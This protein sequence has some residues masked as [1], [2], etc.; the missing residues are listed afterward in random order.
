[1]VSFATTDLYLQQITVRANEV[2]DVEVTFWKAFVPCSTAVGLYTLVLF[3]A[4]TDQCRG[5]SLFY[6]EETCAMKYIL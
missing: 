2:S 5:L 4:G 1:V 6:P 3:H